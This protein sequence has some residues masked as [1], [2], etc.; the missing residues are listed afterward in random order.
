[1]RTYTTVNFLN[2]FE[3]S[4]LCSSKLHLFYQK[5]NKNSNIVKY[6]CNLK[7]NLNSGNV[8]MFFSIWIKWKLKEFQITWANILFTIELRE[9]NK[10]LNWEI[11]QFYAQ[12]ELISNLMP[13]I[14][15]KIV[16]TG[17]CLPWCSISS[18]KKFEDVWASRLWVSGVLVLEFVSILSWYRFP[19]AEEFVV[20]FEVFFV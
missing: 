4:I 18:S 8:G 2:V 16:G 17:A 20:V 9:H 7:C 11:L 19:A 5:Y 3:R 1:M 10:C 14:G 6:Y 13:A 12:N 15:L